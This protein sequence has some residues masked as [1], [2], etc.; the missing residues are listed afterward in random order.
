M[1]RRQAFERMVNDHY[2][3]LLSFAHFLLGERQP[4]EDVAH[5]AFMLAFERLASGQTFE[6]DPGKWLRGAVRNLVREHWRKR[7]GLPHDVADLLEEALAEADDPGEAFDWARLR[8]ALRHCLGKLTPAD[9]EL[10]GQRYEH[11]HRIAD[12]AARLGLNLATARVRLFR[13]RQALKSCVESR[14]S[15][16]VPI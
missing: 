5:Q 9:R 14:F 10:I 1:D 2:E 12:I 11:G 3:A 15:E 6:G 13:I 16:D 4:V 7:K 8:E